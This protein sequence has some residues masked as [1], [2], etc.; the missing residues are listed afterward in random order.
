MSRRYSISGLLHG[1]ANRAYRVEQ[2]LFP[3]ASKLVARP[4]NLAA[5]VDL[6]RQTPLP[7]LREPG[8]IENELLPQLGLNDE[9]L[10]E[11]P[12]SLAKYLGRGFGW[13]IWQ[14]PNQFS[15]YLV[16]LSSV[17]PPLSSYAEIGCR[18]GGTFVLTVEYLARFNPEFSAALAVDLIDESELLKQ[19]HQYRDFQY[20][21][22]SSTGP[23]FVN[24]MTDRHYDLAFIDTDHSFDGI[25]NEF[26]IMSDSNVVAL[27]D[28][29]SPRACPGTTNFWRSLRYFRR[30]EGQFYAFLDQY[31][32]VE[33][34]PFMGLGVMVRK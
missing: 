1:A 9:L 25:L 28:I 14:Y 18:F 3:E 29:D 16:F 13:R 7:R 30:H 17:T 19:Y 34:G 11:Q 27:H 26:D 2:Y 31:S 22:G 20:F 32:D 21:Q 33:D 23:E 15:K 24:M 10:H 8:F 5:G 6:L 4:F 12:A